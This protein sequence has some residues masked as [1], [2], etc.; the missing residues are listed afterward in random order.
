[1]NIKTFILIIVFLIVFSIIFGASF[2]YAL[3]YSEQ[4]KILYDLDLYLGRSQTSY[5]PDLKGK[6]TRQDASIMLLRI[7]GLEDKALE[8]GLEEARKML[9]NDFVDSNEIAD[10]AVRQ[11]AFATKEKIIRGFPDDRF[12][13]REL[14]TGKQYCALVLRMLG[15][16]DELDKLGF[17]FAGELFSQISGISALRQN[18]FNVDDAISRQ[19]L[20]GISFSALNT[21]LK[22]DE[23][24]LAEYLVKKG[25]VDKEQMRE[26]FFNTDNDKLRVLEIYPVS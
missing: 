9:K 15:Y 21:N 10:Y 13:P 16:K 17:F 23:L 1:M 6:V 18:D 5:E 19:I 20:V 22:G 25:V 24:T 4:A 7:F 26:K 11:V 2:S 3:D 12:A 8:L 14:I